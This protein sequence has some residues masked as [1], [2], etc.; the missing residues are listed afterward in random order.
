[1]RLVAWSRRYAAG[2]PKL[3]RSAAGRLYPA[4]TILLRCAL[5][6]LRASENLPYESVALI[7]RRLGCSAY[8][9]KPILL[10]LPLDALPERR[11]VIGVFVK[12]ALF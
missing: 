11:L 9:L 3:Q 12:S 4:S 6:K 2:Q 8:D 5:Q 7:L 1:M 10:S